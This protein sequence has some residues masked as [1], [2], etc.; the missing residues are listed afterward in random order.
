MYDRFMSSFS[1]D[2]DVKTRRSSVL[3]LTR[4]LASSIQEKRRIITA[5]EN[6]NEKMKQSTVCSEDTRIS[7]RA[8]RVTQGSLG[9]QQ[10]GSF[11]FNV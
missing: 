6:E 11:F 7:G 3:R 8:E 2:G 5:I 9:S 4:D 10:L 1:D